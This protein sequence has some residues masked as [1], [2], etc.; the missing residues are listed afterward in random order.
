MALLPADEFNCIFGQLQITSGNRTSVE[1]NLGVAPQCSVCI[2]SCS[3]STRTHLNSKQL[4]VWI[5]G[6]VLADVYYTCRGVASTS[7]II[8]G[9]KLLCL[10]AGIVGIVGMYFFVRLALRQP[11]LVNLIICHSAI[12][13]DRMLLHN[14]GQC[15]RISAHLG[16]N[17]KGAASSNAKCGSAAGSQ[18]DQVHCLRSCE[19]WELSADEAELHTY[20]SGFCGVQHSYTFTYVLEAVCILS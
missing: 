20:I 12:Q 11:V 10:V 15:S 17:Q 7:G 18:A 3:F 16:S 6:Y 13:R 14:V 2:F 4:T 19:G 8:F 9:L 5:Q 1:I